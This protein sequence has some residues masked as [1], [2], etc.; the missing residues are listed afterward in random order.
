MLS[1]SA[2]GLLDLS[3]E[4]TLGKTLGE[5]LPRD[6]PLLDIVDAAFGVKQTLLRTNVQLRS[7]G[8][9]IMVR[10][11]LLEEQHRSL[12]A[13]VV[14]RD[15]ESV[16]HLE[17]QLE[18]A[19]KLAAFNSLSSGIAHE[20]KNPLNAI[21]IHLELLRAKISAES[22]AEMNLSIITQEIKRLDR[23]VKN[24]L[25][26]NRPLQVNLQE[27]ELFP[28]IREV[29]N[30]AFTNA[31]R[32]NVQI[33]VE[34]RNGLPKIRLDRDLIK[35]CLLNIVLNGCQ[36][37]PQGGELRIESAIQKGFLEIRVKDSGIGISPENRA[38]LFKLY[39]TTK[40]NGNGIGLA[41]VFK[42]VQLHNG[43]ILVDSELGKGSTFTVR[44]PLA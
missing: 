6:H 26:F 44:I 36:A 10:V 39:F 7:S 24:F 27:V 19:E 33:L 34:D 11:H 43:E 8:N 25:N 42:I 20:I 32:F 3:T 22:P 35:Q 12:G 15:P 30:L 28:L 9:L 31:A 2:A 16:A 37:M 38:K 17:T 14:L 23:V 13:L 40:E 4:A 41:T 5:V 21:V 18:Y 1:P 29:V